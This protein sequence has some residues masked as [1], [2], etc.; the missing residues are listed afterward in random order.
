MHY[1]WHRHY[2]PSLGRYTQPDPLGFVDGPSVY[3]YAGG[4]SVAYV[5]KDG[6]LVWVIGGIVVGIALEAAANYLESSCGCSSASGSYSGAA[7]A[8]AIVGDNIDP[9]PKP[10]AGIAQSQA[11]TVTSRTAL[12]MDKVFGMRKLPFGLR[13]WAP[14]WKRPL[15]TSSSVARILGRGAPIASVLYGLYDVGRVSR[16][17]YHCVSR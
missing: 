12:F 11:S 8:G 7:T 15:S 14:T 13:G 6:R 17:A 10:R 4:N 3:A 9:M 5:D 16:A 1:N 2:D